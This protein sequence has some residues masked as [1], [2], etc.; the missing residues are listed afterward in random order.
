MSTVDVLVVGAGTAGSA[1]AALC[2]ERGLSVHCIDRRP[3]EQAGAQ[4]LNGVPESAFDRAGFARPTAPELRGAGGNFH[5]VAGWDGPQVVIS[6]HEVL[7]VD[8][9]FLSR[10][11]RA[12]AREA[13]ASFEGSCRVSGFQE[14]P[15]GGV[16]VDSSRGSLSARWLVDASGLTGARLLNQATV[17]PRDLCAAAQ[18]VHRVQDEYAARAYFESRGVRPGSAL[19]FSGVAGGFSVLT[20]RLDGDEVSILT[21]SIP[22]EGHASGLSILKRFV[23]EQDWVGPRLFGGARAI[24]LRRPL[25]CIASGSVALVGDAACQVF[26]AHGSGIAAGMIAARY[27]ADALADGRDVA[28]YAVDWQR[29]YG[30]LYAAYDVFRRFSQTLR[31][32]EVARLV[33]TGLLDADGCLAGLNQQWPRLGPGALLA[34]GLGAVKAPA[35][36]VRF[37]PVLLRMG[38]VAAMYRCY[39][40]EGARRRFWSSRVAR[41]L[42]GVAQ[43]RGAVDPQTDATTESP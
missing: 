4:W 22:S 16:V 20:V 6:G 7:E 11:L 21:G 43:S 25:D 41:Q 35:L 30:A 15:G 33:E 13:G 34:R 28:G 29:E 26:P 24:P 14:R 10:R 31:V 3:L 5:L 36:A 1:V 9:R 40:V 38:L 37:L 8:M 23:S 27:L 17:S 32:E 18:Q 42:P 39:P 2:A 12:L 19:S